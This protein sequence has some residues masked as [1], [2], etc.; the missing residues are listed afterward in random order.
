MQPLVGLRD[1][2]LVIGAG[3]YFVGYIVWSI[4]AW[5]QN[6]GLLPVL[7][8]QYISPERQ[9]A[10]FFLIAGVLARGL[11]VTRTR[12]HAWLDPS[13]EW[14]LAVRWLIAVICNLTFLIVI[15][16]SVVQSE[17]VIWLIGF[18]CSRSLHFH[19]ACSGGSEVCAGG[20]CPTC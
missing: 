18:M 9:S 2:F 13:V 14:K 5:I 4:Y 11:W 19:G 20:L 15:V 17:G 12:L 10:C 7:S 6:L 1:G 8:T 3:L 16:S